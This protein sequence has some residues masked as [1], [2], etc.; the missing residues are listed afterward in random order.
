MKHLVLSLF[1]LIVSTSVYSEEIPIE[2]FF[3]YPDITSIRLSPDGKHITAAVEASGK[4]KLVVFDLKNMKPKHFVNFDG[5]DKE[6]GSFGW[7]NNERIYYHLVRKIGPLDQPAPTGYMFARNIDGSRPAQ[8]M[9]SKAVAGRPADLPARFDVINSLVDD[10]EHILIVKGENRFATAFKLNIYTGRKYQVEKSPVKDGTLLADNSGKVVVATGSD[11][12]TEKYWIYLKNAKGEWKQFKE[13]DSKEVKFMPRAISKDNQYLIAEAITEKSGRG[14]YKLNL[15]SKELDLVL[16]INDDAAITDFLFDGNPKEPEMIGIKR[17]PGYEITDY[18]DPKHPIATIH[19]SLQKAFPN[20]AVSVFDF[21]DDGKNALVRVWSDRNPG[22][23]FLFD[24]ETFK[25]NHLVK[26]YPWI[27]RA[28]TASMKPIK[29]EARDGL[30]IRGYLTTPNNKDKNLPM[31]VMVHGGPYGVWDKWGYDPEVQFLAN[32]GYAVLQVNFR[33]SGGRS[34]SFH[35]DAYQQ[36][37]QE[38]QDDV[39]DGTLWAIENG[40]AD[41]DRI[42]IYGGSYGG[43]ASMMGVIREPDLYKCAIPYVGAFD[44]RAFKYDIYHKTEYG[45]KFA[46]EA[47]GYGDEEFMK[48]HSPVD[49]VN[50]IK[51]KLF[52]AHG[53]R[54]RI[55]PMEHYDRLTEA[56]DEIDYPYE[57]MVKTYEGHGY[58]KPENKFELYSKMESF[59][60]ENI[61]G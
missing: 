42:C 8:L 37:G 48:K 16:A 40:Y 35:Y 29:F 4:K 13:Y 20:D 15:K 6:I 46:R 27:D 3:K 49:H 54:D 30:E 25:L 14:I 60:A 33:G 12:E 39:T 59:L 51:A 19:R 55:C 17:M 41:K 53:G 43:Y 32:R 47:W 18:F 11:W 10:E 9:P 5:E 24:R 7:L 44:I 34:S 26:T 56:L 61:G 2:T 23:Y 38:M 22:E 45:R 36:V 21:T 58:F 28:K 1:C 57:S 52:I 31:V 50:K